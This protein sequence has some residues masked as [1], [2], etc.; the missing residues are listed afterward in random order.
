MA[1]I[2]DPN[3]LDIVALKRKSLSVH[4]EAMFARSTFQTADMERQAE[5]LDEVARLMDA[6]TLRTTLS[7]QFGPFT[8]ANLTRAMPSSKAERRAAS[9]CSKA[10]MKADRSP[11]DA[12]LRGSCRGRRRDDQAPAPCPARCVRPPQA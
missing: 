10:S 3:S 2:G 7:E 11:D 5:L 1:L 9:S 12:T 4:W 8:V 6:G